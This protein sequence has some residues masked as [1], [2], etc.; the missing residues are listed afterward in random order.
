MTSILRSLETDMLPTDTLGT[1]YPSI[2]MNLVLFHDFFPKFGMN[3][4]FAR[5]NLNVTD[6]SVDLNVTDYSKNP[7]FFCKQ[8][9]T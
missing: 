1:L 9:Q 3:V 4:N 8:I 5:V 6:D 2:G 7:D